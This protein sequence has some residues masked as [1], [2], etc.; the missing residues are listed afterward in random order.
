MLRDARDPAGL[1]RTWPTCRPGAPRQPASLVPRSAASPP[2]LG[3]PARPVSRTG[4]GTPGG[5]AEPLNQPRRTTHE[6]APRRKVADRIQV[7]VAEMLERRIKDPR[8]GFVTVTDV[9]VSGDTQNATIFYTVLGEVDELA[10][11]AAAL[12]SA[13]GI[14]R[15]EVG[16]QLG[17]RHVADAGVHP[18]RPARHRPPPRRAAGQGQGVRRRGRRRGGRRAVR[19]RGRP[20]Q[21]A[22]RRGR[23]GRHR[24]RRRG[25]GPHHRRVSTSGA[26]GAAGRAG[27]VVVDKAG[28]MTS[29]DVVARL[30]RLAGTRKVGHAGTLDPMATGVLAARREPGHPAARPPG[31]HREGVRRGGPARVSTTTDDA[32]GEVLATAD[33]AH[34][35]DDDGARGAGRLRRRHRAG[36][37]LGVRDQGRR[38]ARLREGPRR[39]E[40]RA[41]RAAG[42][43]PR[44]RHGRG[45]PRRRHGRRRDLGPLLQRHLHPRVGPRPGRRPRRRRAPHRAPPYRRRP[46]RPRRRRDPRPAR[47]GVHDGARSTTWHGA[48]S[49]PSTVDEQGAADVAVG[50]KLELD[51]GAP[52]RSRSSTARAGSSPCT[53]SAA[54]WP[55]RSP[56]SPP[57]RPEVSRAR[58]PP[59]WQAFAGLSR[60]RTGAPRRADLALDRRRSRRPRSDGRDDRQLRRGTPRSPA[61]GARAPA[62]WPATAAWSTWSRSPSTRTRSRCCA[63]STRHPP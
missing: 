46:L 19:R 6:L 16:K 44:A 10:G 62:R 27:L 2:S 12:E 54:R 28:G 18:R 50:R 36:A 58:R 60:P 9:R 32:E 37:L 7:I 59:V 22:P 61:R 63:P 38:P 5:H 56:S 43:R 25:R 57:E 39:R 4:G 42:H 35:T 29:H 31:A 34:L 26:A 30:R 45:H 8:L 13:K 14:L 55:P 40:G 1:T 48:A 23:R 33:A 11:T 17:M 52:G 47:R 15:S 20:L 3:A 51:L 49:R 21:E 41:G 24:R 53:S